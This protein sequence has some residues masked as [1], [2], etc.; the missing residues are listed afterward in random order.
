M[1]ELNRNERYRA[2]FEQS[3]EGIWCFEL[4]EPLPVELPEDEQ[5][6][7]MFEHAH[8]VECNDAMARMYGV[9]SASELIGAPLR[10]ML[11][12]TDPANLDYLRSF[13]RSGYRLVD[14]E[15][16]EVDQ[17]GHPK[18]FLNNLVGVIESGRLLRAWGTQ[19]DVTEARRVEEQIR[20]LHK[21]EAVAR[22]AGGVAH[23]F[24]NLLTAIVGHADLLRIRLSADD[25]LRRHAEAIGR[26]ATEAAALTRQ[27]LAFGRRQVLQPRV[28]A[29]NRVIERLRD[30]IRRVLGE[31]AELRLSLAPGLGRVKADQSQ[32]EE[33]LMTLVVH[34]RDA[35]P[36]GGVVTI[37]TRNEGASVVVSVSDTGAGLDDLARVHLFEP[38]FGTSDGSRGAGLALATVDG[39]VEQ[40]GGSLRVESTRGQGTTIEVHLPLVEEEPMPAPPLVAAPGASGTETILLVEDEEA[41][42]DLTADLLRSY[43]YTVLTARNADEAMRLFDEDQGSI[44]ALLTDVVMPGTSGPELA[45]ALIARQPGLKVLC[46]SGYADSEVVRRQ[47]LDRGMAFLQKPFSAP[48]LARRLRETL[49]AAPP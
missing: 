37:A 38:F 31:S 23:D 29:L 14:A 10:D 5:I 8:L 28:L 30:M 27:L 24:N 18:V 21:M 16:R 22:L 33:V 46:M 32:L 45:A 34:A 25:P 2:F 40:S 48:E 11:V 15:S 6:D 42:R 49:D 7:R 19:R 13:I 9:T 43:G 12:R 44:A 4:R 20:Q 3:S 36:Q 17:R 47:V 1:A 39:I 41:V 26:A 35:M